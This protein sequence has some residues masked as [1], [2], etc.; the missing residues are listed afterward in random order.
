M[1]QT[2]KQ[3][4]RKRAQKNFIFWMVVLLFTAFLYFFFQG[5]YPNYR[6]LFHPSEE[7]KKS[8]LKPFGIIDIHVFPS[9]DSILVNDSGYNNSSRTIFDL[10][11]YM[12]QIQKEGYI[13]LTLPIEITQKNPF[14]SS[15]FN[16]LR[17][18]KYISTGLTFNHIEK[19][20]SV[21][22]VGSSSKNL[23]ILDKNRQVL[24]PLVSPYI[25]LGSSY[26]RG[27]DSTLF[28]YEYTT[29][30]FTQV[31]SK[32]T[33]KPLLCKE[34]KIYGGTP[35]CPDTRKFI[36]SHGID[37]SEKI[38]AANHSIVTT[39]TYIYN[40]DEKNTDWKYYEYRNRAIHAPTTLF[41]I[42]KIPFVLENG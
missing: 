34:W 5:Y 26:F 15:T 9:P 6:E 28:S 41:H 2:Y 29:D 31:L 37:V 33:G 40:Q 42:N 27:D 11:T 21:Y 1:I 3:E 4:L 19:V 13:H 14:Y 8:F 35:F 25:Y 7:S 36:D 17:L 38:L 16:L 23:L 22:F 12:V 10:G 32:E 20:A 30:K 24:K 18:P 39:D